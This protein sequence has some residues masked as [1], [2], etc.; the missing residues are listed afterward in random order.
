VSTAAL[1]PPAAHRPA[2]RVISF[3]GSSVEPTGA[4]AMRH[5][6]A[7]PSD[8]AVQEELPLAWGYERCGAA[9]AATLGSLPA[10]PLDPQVPRPHPHIAQAARLYADV[11][12]GIRPATHLQHC[13][14]LDVQQQ[15]MRRCRRLR[16]QQ[17]AQTPAVLVSTHSM[18]LSGR[19]VMVAVVFRAAGRAHA[20]ALRLEYR[21]GRW[22]VTAAESPA[23]TPTPR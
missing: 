19:V 4:G 7:A 16:A 6:E 22:M 9:A 3:G 11:L 1:T 21:H 10:L 15:T 18:T 8:D 17:A 23:P 2:L 5:E 13:A 12:A 20:A 14:S